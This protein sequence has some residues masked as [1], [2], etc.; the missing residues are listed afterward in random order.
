MIKNEPYEFS[1]YLIVS[2][3][4]LQSANDSNMDEEEVS[5]K[6]RAKKQK[7]QVIAFLPRLER[8]W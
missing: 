4:Y 2:R 1:H 5:V 6:P 8:C 3:T 7:R